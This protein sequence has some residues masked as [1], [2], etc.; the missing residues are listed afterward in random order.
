MDKRSVLGFILI[1]IVL[2]VWLYWN[3]GNQQKTTQN[4]K[5]TQD[6]ILSEN[7]KINQDKEK[8]EKLLISESIDS[9]KQTLNN[10]SLAVDS[11]KI[12]YGNKFYTSSINYPDAAQ[13]K[14]ITV[15]NNLTEI[16]FSNYGGGLKMYTIKNTET[17]DKKPLQLVDWR[18]GKELH[19]LFTSKEGRSI[20]TKDFVF[21]SDFTDNSKINIE[22]DGSYKLKFTL[23]LDPNGTEKI[24]KTYSFHPD[25]YEFDVNYEFVN[26]GK[27]IADN[28]YQI[29]WE[30]SLNLSE[31]RSDQEATFAEAS[32]YMGGELEYI[33]ATDDTETYREDLN[34]NTDF[35][36]MRTKYF[37][38]YIIPTE[39]KGDGAYLSGY[40]ENLKDQGLMENYSIAVKMD[41]KNSS[42]EK[43]AFKILIAP[44]DYSLLKSYELELEKTLRFSLDFIVRPIAQYMILPVFL[45]LHSFIPSWGLVIIL[46]ALL[47]KIVLNPLTKT[48]MN[49]MKKLSEI[50][51]KITAIREKYKDDPVKAN[52]QIMKMYKEEK[53]NPA[54]GCLPML[55]QLPILYALFGVFNSTIELRHASFLWIKDLSAPDVILHLPFK[56]PLFGIDDISG[57]ALLMGITMFIQQKMTITDPK[58][59]AMVYIMPVMLTLLFFSFPAG[60]NLYY[61]SFNLFSIIQQYYNKRKDSAKELDKENGMK[62]VTATVL[63]SK[64]KNSSSKGF[65]K[66]KK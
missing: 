37:G 27:F 44:L 34:G 49:S 1:G 60:L 55:L 10:D 61:F 53:I 33:D 19:L 66:L 41:I 28:K 2:M 5:R 42:L 15:S 21:E 58:Q 26:P 3:S 9:L 6:S 16:V 14:V 11:L 40:K 25:K 52:Q 24:I 56:I 35:V 29:V 43:S 62:T 23:N 50:N 38:L 47:L 7:E 30:S 31:F 46:F 8:K 36:S 54:G 17:W 51:P 64:K 18:A 59:K 48:Q 12:K 39:R 20:N 22:N 57:I 4:L 32:A 13:E 65:K 45:F 63:E